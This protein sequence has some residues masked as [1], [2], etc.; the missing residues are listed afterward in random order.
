MIRPVQSVENSVHNFRSG[1]TYGNTPGSREEVDQDLTVLV[2]NSE[3]PFHCGW[4]VVW[5]GCFFRRPKAG[6]LAIA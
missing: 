3:T 2:L 6:T 4:L 1:L 5:V